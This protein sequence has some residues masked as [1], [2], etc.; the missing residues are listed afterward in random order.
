MATSLVPSRPIAVR[1]CAAGVHQKPDAHRRKSSPS[2]W[3]SP[4]FGWSSDPDYID[5][6]PEEEAKAKA[7]RGKSGSDSA[8]DP[9]RSRF[10]PGSF[11][12]EKARRLRMMTTETASFHDVMYHSAIASRLASDFKD[13]SDR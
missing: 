8:P 10:A 6:D 11:T 13:R 3:W 12:A 5:S 1:A 2:N 7:E 9:A 4:I